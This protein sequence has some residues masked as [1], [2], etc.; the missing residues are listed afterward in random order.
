MAQTQRFDQEAATWDENPRRVR[1][2]KAVAET[3]ARQVPLA[4]SMKVLDF[5][6]GTGLLTL[7][8][9]PLVGEI[10]G[11]D[12]ST[13]ML[14]VLQ[15]K[16]SD[17]GLGPVR[18]IH[19]EPGRALPAAATFDLVTSSMTLHHVKDLE[20]LFRQFH[21]C[22][23][24]GGRIALADLDAEDG[25]FHEQADDVHHLGFER[26]ALQ[27][28]LAGAGFAGLEAATAFEIRRNGRDYPVF[29][30]TGSKAG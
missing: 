10:T 4:R 23:R 14:E 22:L 6:C 28:L 16:V 9:L 17:L 29:L 13:G 25:T 24:P 30:I 12:T 5:G 21:A 2:A 3:I 18:T 27:E 26:P 7:N 19:L 20:A 1:L 15:R 8:L 11:A